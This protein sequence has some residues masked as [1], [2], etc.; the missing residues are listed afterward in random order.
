MSIKTLIV[1]KAAAFTAKQINKWKK[2]A[3][4]DQQSIMLNLVNQAQQTVF[5]VDHHFGNIKTYGDFKKSIRIPLKS[6][7]TI[8]RVFSAQK[9]RK[10]RPNFIS[11]RQK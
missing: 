4:K 5:G 7:P 10:K 1:K 9:S 2:T 6:K 11:F 8:H 3:I